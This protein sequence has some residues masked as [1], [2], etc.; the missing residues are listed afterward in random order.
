MLIE[1]YEAYSFKD[2]DTFFNMFYEY[3]EELFNSPS[4]YYDN[5]NYFFSKKYKEDFLSALDRDIS[6][7]NLVF[8]KNEEKI[9]GFSTYM[10]LNHLGG[11]AII[12]EFCINKDFRRK[13]LGKASLSLLLKKIKKEGGKT[14][15]LTYTNNEN[16]KFWLKEGFSP[17]SIFYY[18][19][20][21]ILIKEI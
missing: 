6:P 17:S 8:F 15:E 12:L 20:R 11:K 19:G 16:K 7:L 14:V 13:N 9:L 4:S 10:I 5:S 2:L 18:D 3:V 1:I 21:P